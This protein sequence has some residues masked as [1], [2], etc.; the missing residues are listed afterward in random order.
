[1]FEKLFPKI[2]GNNYQGHRIAKWLL[3]LY[4]AKSL[5][6]ASVHMFAADG[7]AQSIGS[8]A[9]DQFS[10][11]GANSVI[12]MFGLW[13][14]EQLVIGL[15]AIVILLRYKALIPM[16][17]LVYVIEYT[18]RFTAHLY[19]PGL[20]TA[21]TPPGAVM[22]NILFPLAMIMLVLSLKTKKDA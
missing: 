15:I 20:V 4:V 5:F 7:G 13:G 22:D 1:M 17:A 14:M 3:I 21:H 18:G 12:T 10:L 8:V 2:V 6:A 16:M 11:G 19:T 9:L